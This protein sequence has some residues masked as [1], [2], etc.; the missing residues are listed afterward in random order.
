MYGID[1]KEALLVRYWDIHFTFNSLPCGV[2][3]EFHDSIPSFE[4]WYGNKSK[5]YTDFDELIHDKFFGGNSLQEL[6]DTVELAFH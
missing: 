4:S 3:T 1:L 6:K 2:E 5:K